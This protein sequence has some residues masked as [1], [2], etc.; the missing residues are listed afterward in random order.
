MDNIEIWVYVMIIYLS[1]HGIL[2]LG[3]YLYK[4]YKELMN[5]SRAQ[6]EAR[7]KASIEQIEAGKG[8]K[9]DLIK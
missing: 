2:L 7:L 3:A 6:N 9:H 8:K 4:L 1:L 5:L